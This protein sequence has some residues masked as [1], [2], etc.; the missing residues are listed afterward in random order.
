MP[1]PSGPLPTPVVARPDTGIV[2]RPDTGTVVRPVAGQG[3][4]AAPGNVQ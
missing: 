1:V 3:D 4:P 2:A